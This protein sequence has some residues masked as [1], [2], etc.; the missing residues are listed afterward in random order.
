MTK[1]YPQSHFTPLTETDLARVWQWRN[2]TNIRQN[3][4]NTNEISWDEH[5]RWFEQLP[6]SDKRFYVFRQNDRAIG[7]LYF[8]AYGDDGLEW[9]CYL[10]E[11]DVWPGSGLLLE[12]AALDY[13][14][15]Q[16]HITHLHAE[17]LSLNQSV[18][19]MHQLFGYQHCPDKAVNPAQHATSYCIKVFEYQTAAWRAERADILA[20]LPRQIAAAADYIHFQD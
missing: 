3:M 8:D 9:G 10:G 2:Q 12:I 15:A 5:Q 16:P 14:A 1:V 7:A 19:K 17:V 13:A 11:T 18:L 20:R 6:K 4:H